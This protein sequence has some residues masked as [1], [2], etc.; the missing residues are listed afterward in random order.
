MLVTNKSVPDTKVR[1]GIGCEWLLGLAALKRLPDVRLARNIGL[2]PQ[3][4]IRMGGSAGSV[5][6]NLGEHAARRGSGLACGW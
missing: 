6:E 3:V 4:T 5:R 2:L 1:V